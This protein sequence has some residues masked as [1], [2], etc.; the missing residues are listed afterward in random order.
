MPT[1]TVTTTPRQEAALQRAAKQ[2]R[3]TPAARAQEAFDAGLQ[4]DLH[5]MERARERR[6][7]DRYIAADPLKRAAVDT[8]LGLDNE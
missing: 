2:A 3:Q 4:N 8:A 5:D 6:L 1:Y 7:Q